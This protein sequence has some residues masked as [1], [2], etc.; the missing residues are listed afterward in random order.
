MDGTEA[1]LAVL[2]TIQEVWLLLELTS[3]WGLA[4]PD[5]EWV[6]RF[7][8]ID[9]PVGY[10]G[11]D[12]RGTETLSAWLSE[13]TTFPTAGEAES[14]AIQLYSAPRVARRYHRPKIHMIAR[15]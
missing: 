7:E 11:K 1:I 6:I 5:Q 12:E 13:A 14:K 2:F 8:Q 3:S 15:L 10:Y 4:M 9:G